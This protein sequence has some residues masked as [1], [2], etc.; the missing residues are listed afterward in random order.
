MGICKSRALKPIPLKPPSIRRRRPKG[1]EKKGTTRSTKK[2]FSLC[3]CRVSG[4]NLLFRTGP[5]EPPI[6]TPAPSVPGVRISCTGFFNIWLT[7]SLPRRITCTL[8]ES[9]NTCGLNQGKGVSRPN[10]RSACG[11]RSGPA[12]DEGVTERQSDPSF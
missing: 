6:V 2:S 11:H 9:C 1:P 8:S 4:G 3:A 12:Y 5:I 7:S 10:H